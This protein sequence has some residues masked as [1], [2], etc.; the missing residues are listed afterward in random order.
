MR[1]DAS[2]DNTVPK[3]L[4]GN[5]S[6]K[7]KSALI[8]EEEC[9]FM[10]SCLSYKRAKVYIFRTFRILILLFL[11][12]KLVVDVVHDGLEGVLLV[13]LVAEADGV[14]DSQL[15]LHVRLVQVVGRGLEADGVL[16]RKQK[17]GK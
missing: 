2:E 16:P 17:S 12:L 6:W 15:Q 11:T 5:I 4:E 1:S 13:D 14:A 7:K 8:H 3:G 9:K 10:A